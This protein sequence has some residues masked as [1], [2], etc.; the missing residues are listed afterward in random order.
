M[1][2]F[3]HGKFA[4]GPMAVDPASPGF[5]YGVGF[6][7]TLYYNGSQL[8]HLG[9]HLDRLI[10]SLRAHNIPYQAADFEQIIT[11]VLARNSLEASPA[12]VNIVYSAER[13]EAH[14]IVMAAPYDPQPQKTYRL[15]I[16]EEHHVSSLNAHKSNSY[17]FFHL[18]R[19]RALSRGFDDAA[20]FDL[21]D[22][23]LESTCGAILLKKDGAFFQT[24]TPYKLPSTAL[25]LAETILDIDS[26]AI[27]LNELGSYDHAYLLNS[28][29]GMRPIIAL[30]ETA[31][32]EDWRPCE[33][34]SKVVLAG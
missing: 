32:A 15:S 14:P 2:Y 21:G 11:D 17:L 24:R 27:S 29:I 25:A 20:L 34:V 30:G 26:K 8:C 4:H 13:N 1:I 5:R 12:R 28:L 9:L 33:A 16:C 23:L 6:F 3:A 7:E 31:F 22:N 18:A 10:D 19:Q